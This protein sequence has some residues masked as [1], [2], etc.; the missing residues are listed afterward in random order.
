LALET[1]RLSVL[2]RRELIAAASRL[3]DTL[4]RIK[5]K[6]IISKMGIANALNEHGIPTPR[7]SQWDAKEV[8]RLETRLANLV[9][10]T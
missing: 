1:K 3:Q 5:A 9:Q 2:F 4:I 10:Q 8:I 7:G 6:G